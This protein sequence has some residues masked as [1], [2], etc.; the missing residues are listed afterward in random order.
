MFHILGGGCSYGKARM[1][2]IW[3][4]EETPEAGTA[5]ASPL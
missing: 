5:T 3:G 1:G 4:A 2:K